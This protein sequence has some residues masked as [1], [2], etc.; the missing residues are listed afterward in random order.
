MKEKQ[1]TE[2]YRGSIFT[3]TKD[4]VIINGHTYERDIIHHNGGV[5]VL[6]IQNGQILLVSQYR[7]AI[8]QSSLEIPAGK[9][10]TNEDPY[11]CGLRELEEETGYTSDILHPICAMY[12]TPGFCSE[13]IYLYWS[14]Q[15]TKV[16]QPRAMDE[17]EDIE[18]R[19]V[20]LAEAMTMIQ[21]EEIQDAKTIIALQF[22]ALHGLA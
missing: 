22:A 11:R 3:M 17:D 15:L 5:G 8:G 4:E 16:A 7:F 19:W 9:L 21:R 1:S 12:S 2:L 6:A 20:S 18:I 10:E 13:K 14:D